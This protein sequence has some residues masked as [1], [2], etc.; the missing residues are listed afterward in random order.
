MHFMAREMNEGK[1]IRSRLDFLE[2][3]EKKS[4]AGPILLDVAAGITW[5]ERR[6][7][8]TEPATETIMLAIE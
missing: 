3:K 1:I 8:G 7:L 5:L 4:E 2:A 6:H